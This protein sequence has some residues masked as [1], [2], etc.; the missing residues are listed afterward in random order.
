MLLQ[1][2]LLLLVQVV[3]FKF[4]VMALVFFDFQT[5]DSI[6]MELNAFKISVNISFFSWA[7][8]NPYRCVKSTHETDM[9]CIKCVSCWNKGTD[10]IFVKYISF[11]Y[12]NSLIGRIYQMNVSFEL[13]WEF[14]ST[15]NSFLLAGLVQC[16]LIGFNEIDSFSIYLSIKFNGI[17]VFGYFFEIKACKK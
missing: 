15:N 8:M 14:C 9:G 17:I 6:L 5:L 11:W 3:C 16:E 4:N 12:K 13:T 2:L 1:L 7:T 10:S